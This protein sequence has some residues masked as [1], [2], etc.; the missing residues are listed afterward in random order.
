MIKQSERDWLS[1]ALGIYEARHTTHQGMA[2]ARGDY[3]QSN[4]LCG[5]YTKK[6]VSHRRVGLCWI[7]LIKE[8]TQL[9]EIVIDEVNEN[10]MQ[11]LPNEG[12]IQCGQ[13]RVNNKA[14]KPRSSKGL[15]QKERTRSS[16]QR[17]FSRTSMQ[18]PLI[19]GQV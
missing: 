10:L 4:R 5:V 14:R 8:I 7:G 2:K 9:E 19:I 17:P 3:S 1:T 11:A 16:V 12:N 6:E 18:R 13:R 15:N